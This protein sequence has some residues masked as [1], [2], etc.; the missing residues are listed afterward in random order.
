L[1]RQNEVIGLP[2]L[3]QIVTAIERL[4]PAQLAEEWDRV[5]LQVDR[6]A[7]PVRRVVVAVDLNSQVVAASA[8]QP[9]D[10]FIVHHPFL[11][12]P[13]TRIGRATAPGRMITHLLENNQFVLVAHTNLDRAARGINQY[14]AELL[15]LTQV[16]LLEPAALNAYKLVVFTPESHVEQ[17]YTALTEAGAGEIGNYRGCAFRQPGIGS[18]YPNDQARPYLGQPGSFESVPEIRLEMVVAG[19]KLEQALQAIY[20]HH[21]YEEPALDVYPVQNSTRHGLGRV[22]I[23]PEAV[24]LQRFCELVKT[25][26]PAKWLQVSGEPER[27]IRKVALCSGSGGDLV[28][29]AV[30][31]QA[32]LYLTGELNYHAHWEARE[33]GL[34]VIEAGHGA[35]EQCFVPLLTAHLRQVFAA[36]DLTVVNG[37]LSES[38]PYRIV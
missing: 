26:L 31:R 6:T 37:T 36:A 10:G 25:Q 2:S 38:E 32:D 29:A 17:L 1:A 33:Q 22:G 8:G 14:L 11:F 18:F 16:A 30:Q 4:A 15:G 24:S 34:A 5:G 28:A 13:L 35:T 20:A 19:N 27:M 23:L 21:P 9:V 7:G 3:Q 12:K